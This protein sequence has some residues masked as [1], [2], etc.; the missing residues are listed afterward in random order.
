MY[1]FRLQFTS[2]T[3][4]LL[5]IMYVLSQLNFV[6]NDV[7]DL[8]NLDSE[9]LNMLYEPKPKG[10]YLLPN[11]TKTYCQIISKLHNSIQENRTNVDTIFDSIKDFGGPHFTRAKIYLEPLNKTFN[12]TTNEENTLLKNIADTKE[13][14]KILADALGKNESNHHTFAKWVSDYKDDG[15][16][17]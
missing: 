12:W 8:I 7:I 16:D 10:R 15:V 2:N 17:E 13:Q 9:I 1:R 4:K 11:K 3:M 6:Y 5:I 14:W